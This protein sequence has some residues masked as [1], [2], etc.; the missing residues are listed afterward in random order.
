MLYY[1][2]LDFPLPEIQALK[3]LK[4][5]FHHATRVVVHVKYLVSF[6]AYA[7]LL[8]LFTHHNLL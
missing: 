7:L 3:S 8:N 1:E 4:L 2:V 5:I 6:P